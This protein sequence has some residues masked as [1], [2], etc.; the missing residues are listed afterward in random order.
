M[1]LKL[2]PNTQEL[3]ERARQA[4]LLHS[5]YSLSEVVIGIFVNLF[6]YKSTNSIVTVIRYNL[7]YFSS[8]AIFYI[9]IGYLFKKRGI[10]ILYRASFFLYFIFY[11]SFFFLKENASQFILPLGICGGCAYAFYWAA[12]YTLVLSGTNDDC[13]DLFMG[14]SGSL[15]SLVIIVGTFLVGLVVSLVNK[16]FHS[17]YV[18]YLPV[19][20][21]LALLFIFSDLVIRKTRGLYFDE[22]D[23][24]ESIALIKK[25]VAWRLNIYRCILDGLLILRTYIWALLSYT[26]VVSELKLGFLISI[27]SVISIAV[28]YFIGKTLNS[29]KRIAANGIG[30]LLIMMGGLLFGVNFSIGGLLFERFLADSIGTPLFNISWISIFFLTVEKDKYHPKKQY[31]YFAGYIFTQSLGQF[32]GSIVMIF[33]F[34]YFSEI[35]FSRVVYIVLTF[36]YIPLYF[37]IRKI[38][39]LNTD[40]DE[41]SN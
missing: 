7:I 20:L 10:H 40:A 27:F 34:R 36:A 3:S 16:Y 24:R 21:V 15:N 12:R 31:D 29:S 6:L 37:I 23:I 39:F 2:L 1:R 28:S 41:Y 30:V 17:Q 35:N 22:F 4:L 18:G 5:I 8:G 25:N 38:H 33:L 13:R 11:I 9:F 14:I 19:F 26:I 32:V